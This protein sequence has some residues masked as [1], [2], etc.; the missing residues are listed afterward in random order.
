MFEAPRVHKLVPAETM[1]DDRLAHQYITR[2]CTELVL[3]SV[4]ERDGFIRKFSHSLTSFFVT[5][6]RKTQFNPY[7][8]TDQRYLMTISSVYS[9]AMQICE[10]Y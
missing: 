5:S 6:Q 10:G 3:Y 4:T 7:S 8:A 9:Y 2:I 1:V